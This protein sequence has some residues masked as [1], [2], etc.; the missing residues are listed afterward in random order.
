MCE[1]PARAVCGVATG[2]VGSCA[3][4]LRGVVG[5]ADMAVSL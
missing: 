4:A 3:V 1:V 2:V 5:G